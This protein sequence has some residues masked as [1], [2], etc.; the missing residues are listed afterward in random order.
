MGYPAT[1]HYLTMKLNW[2][3]RKLKGINEPSNIKDWTE[4]MHSI[5]RVLE[6]FKRNEAFQPHQR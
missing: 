2:M 6:E 5:Y 1:T 4:A 3:T